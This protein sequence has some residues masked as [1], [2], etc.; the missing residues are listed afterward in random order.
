MVTPRTDECSF[1]ALEAKV[2]LSA[3]IFDVDLIESKPVEDNSLVLIQ[4]DLSE[5]QDH[6]QSGQWQKSD[7]SIFK[8]HQNSNLCQGVLNG[9]VQN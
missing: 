7:S 2:L 9:V 5:Q 1:E 3:S 8:I 4:E 6:R